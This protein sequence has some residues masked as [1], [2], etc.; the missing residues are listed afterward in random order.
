MKRIQKGV[1]IHTEERYYLTPVA[2]YIINECFPYKEIISFN[3]HGGFQL[4]CECPH[5]RRPELT[6]A[7]Q[8][9]N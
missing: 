5:V 8:Y 1:K 3:E 4:I 6:P 7:I 9:C 2:T